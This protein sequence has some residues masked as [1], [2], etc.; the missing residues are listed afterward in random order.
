M[1]LRVVGGVGMEVGMDPSGYAIIGQFH[2]CRRPGGLGDW[3]GS[4]QGINLSTASNR[5]EISIGSFAADERRTPSK[6]WGSA[7]ISK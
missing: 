5:S 1:S 4:R 6:V 7:G 3:D 2:R